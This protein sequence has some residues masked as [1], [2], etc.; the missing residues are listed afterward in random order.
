MS[1]EIAQIFN[2]LASKL[3][4]KDSSD[5]FRLFD[6]VL[7]KII[8]TL[9]TFALIAFFLY[10]IIGAIKWIISGGDKGQ[11]ESA[12]NQITH[13]LLGLVILLS[14]FAIARIIETLFGVCIL[15]IDLGPLKITGSGAG[16]ICGVPLP[17]TYP[18]PGLPP[19][20]RGSQL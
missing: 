13:A 11:L 15:N 18:T 17:A 10:L 6:L 7:Q 19:G 14:L 4:P 20:D 12:R 16:H 5:G 8:G 3:N 9:F 1:Q 2:P